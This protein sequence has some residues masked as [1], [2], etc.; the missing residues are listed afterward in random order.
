[1]PTVYSVGFRNGTLNSLLGKSA[2]GLFYSLHFFNGVQPADPTVAPAGSSVFTL[3]FSSGL[4][5]TGFM[6][7]P[8]LGVSVLAAPRSLNAVSTVSGITFARM[9]DGSVGTG[10]ADMSV[11]LVGG[12]GGV[13]VPSLSSTAG[14]A[15]QVDA[16]SL[17]LPQTL[18][19]IML[20]A[21]L[22]N[23]LT[24]LW[25]L[26]PANTNIN[27][28][29][30]ASI[31][32]YSGAAPASADAV[33]TGTLLVSFTTAAS[34]AS[35]GTVSGGAA[36]LAS[37]LSAVASVTGTAG[38]VRMVKGAMI[39]QGSVGTTGTDFILDTVS[40]VSAATITLTEATISL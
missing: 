21:D 1:M 3:G 2:S 23:A 25:A 20:N 37:N 8:A 30:S 29:G 14:V 12:G 4:L 16:F 11:S 28:G 19:T 5:T 15:F 18:G 32:V 9:Y 31:Q 35:W 13:I 6:S 34:G 10:V 36:A 17:K 39:L 27:F 24:S 22:V 40:I 33:A 7:A 38:Y 26:G